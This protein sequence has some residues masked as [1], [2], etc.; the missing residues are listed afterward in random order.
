MKNKI[1]SSLRNIILVVFI[2]FS[3]QSIA[4]AP[5]NPPGGSGGTTNNG[6]NQNGGNAPI[7]GGL[8]ILIGL[9]AAYGG[10][11]I[12]KLYKEGEETLED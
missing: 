4:Q 11:K 3:F 7:G 6:G 12:Y 10:R 2:A 5:P 8:F 9:G 1:Y